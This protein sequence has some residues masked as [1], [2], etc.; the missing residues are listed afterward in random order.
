MAFTAPKTGIDWQIGQYA[1]TT[2]SSLGGKIVSSTGPNK[3]ATNKFD[4]STG[5]RKADLHTTGIFWHIPFR[6]KPQ[7]LAP[8]IVGKCFVTNEAALPYI[9]LYTDN[10]VS[11][12]GWPNSL[13]DTCNISF[14][15]E[16][17]AI[18]DVDTI[19]LAPEAKTFTIPTDPEA[20]L[21]N[22]SL[23]SLLI[24]NVAVPKWVTLKL[25]IKNNVQTKKSGN[26]VG[27]TEL[28]AE[29]AE[30]NFEAEIISAAELHFGVDSTTTKKPVA[31][32]FTDNAT[33]AVPVTFTFPEMNLKSNSHAFDGLG[34]TYQKIS[35]VANHLVIS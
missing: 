21:T 5:T 31:L 32:T 9:N 20:P 3:Q 30:Y 23:T 22:E 29:H 26:G 27:M 7:K 35:G 14:D 10:G 2:P 16:G 34:L 17:Y 13:V 18:A 24:N 25:G 19:C 12:N 1:E 28:Y 15:T 8:F 6:L 11:K 4:P 33:P